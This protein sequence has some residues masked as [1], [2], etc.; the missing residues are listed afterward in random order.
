MH[1]SHKNQS[2]LPRWQARRNRLIAPIR[3]P[4]EAVFGSFK[5]LYGRSR[6][7]YCNFLH[8]LADFQRLATIYNLRRAV[9]LCAA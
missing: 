5:R 1:R 2:A 6:V 7:R 9:S 4:V 8:N 3:A